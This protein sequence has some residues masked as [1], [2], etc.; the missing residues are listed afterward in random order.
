LRILVAAALVLLVGCKQPLTSLK[1]QPG[2][3]QAVEVLW[4][5]PEERAAASAVLAKRL[6][7]PVYD[8]ATG[9]QR[10]LRLTLTGNDISSWAG[11]RTR[12]T[13]LTTGAGALVGLV[14]PLTGTVFYLKAVPYTTGAGLLAGMIYGPFAFNANQER[15][16]RLGYYPWTLNAKALELVTRGPD[17]AASR[18]VTYRVPRLDPHPYQHPLTKD[19]L[20]PARIRKESLDAFM[21][22]LVAYLDQQGVPAAGQPGAPR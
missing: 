22:G 21:E 15:L 2:Q 7:V 20:A 10:V 6:G 13:L 14:G 16:G 4:P 8:E 17:G 3:V 5:E 1:T 19:E 18:L 12:T 11:S 9:K